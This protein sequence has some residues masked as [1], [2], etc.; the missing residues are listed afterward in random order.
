MNR[1]FIY[2]KW[3]SDVLDP[4]ILEKKVRDLTSRTQIG[5]IF[6]GM[7]WIREDF[8]GQRVSRAFRKSIQLLHAAGR[9]AIIECCVRGEGEPFSEIYPDE[10]A[11]LVTVR[12]AR[13]DSSGRI[14]IPH[15]QV[16]HYWR[17]A[18]DRGEHR[19]FAL[20]AMEPGPVFR[21][22]EGFASRAVPTENGYEIEISAPG[23]HPGQTLAAVVGFP[24]PIPDLAHPGLIPY[25]R[26]MAR[27]AAGLGADGLFSDE[28]GYDV[29]LDIRK[30]N[31][32]DDEDLAIRHISY[33]AHM[34]RRYR[35]RWDES[36]LD[37][38]IDLFYPGSPLRRQRIDRYLA[39]LRQICTENE[40]AM[41]SVVKEELGADA[42]WGIHPT[43][44]GSRDQQNME[45][46]KNGFY[47]WDA[48][49]DIAQTDESVILP[50]RTAL[51][52][53]FSSPV[54]YNM[55]YSLGTRDIRTYYPETWNNLRFGGRTHYLGYECPNEAVVLDL[56]PV[57][58][59]ESIERMDSRVRL[60]DSVSSQPDCRLLLFFGFEAVS[61]WDTVGMAPPWTPVNPRLMKLLQTADKI[62]GEMLCDLVPSYAAENGSLFLNEAGK[63]QYGNQTY[64]AVI[65]LYPEG[66]SEAAQAF[67][68]SVP[69]E[70]KILCGCAD[71]SAPAAAVFP[72][73]PAAGNLAAMAEFL[74]VP[75]NRTA[76]GCVLQDGSKI[77]TG[78]GTLPTGNP[79]EVEDEIQ[80]KILRFRGKD[81]LWVSADG[82]R[83]IF[84]E[85]QLSV[86]HR[87]LESMR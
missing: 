81:A 6:I 36:L 60:F 16:W 63:P 33:S 31:P 11:Y 68:R 14:R 1:S 38:V 76:N 55:W 53:R 79:L 44:W 43:W 10:P 70:K 87:A 4:D 3:D 27:H 32:Y 24:Q 40:E 57:G 7:E 73:I 8:R 56:R 59:L 34:E 49:R 86:D 5:N 22:A 50:I 45:F 54:W 17:H 9:K 46:F 51:A 25:F 29:I 58:L 61:N 77:F 47:W 67:L 30:P 26:E 85:G 15:E 84:P 69:P 39:L 83:A 18:G 21:K 72:D 28:W 23:I 12:E 35:Q 66:M 42:F 65:A 78:S 41:Y 82:T 74:G 2:W 62:F 20:Y 52:H 13:A 19:V 80:G 71:P 75:R 37:T 48:K 64:D